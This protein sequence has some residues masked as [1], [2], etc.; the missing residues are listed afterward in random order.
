MKKRKTFLKVFIG[1]LLISVPIMLI[2]TIISSC[3]LNHYSESVLL[4]AMD[5]CAE[6]SLEKFLQSEK[7]ST[8]SENCN[9]LKFRINLCLESALAQFPGLK[10]YMYVNDS[11]SILIM[12]TSPAWSLMQSIR[13]ENYELQKRN[14]YICDY[15][16]LCRFEEVREVIERYNEQYDSTL[17]EFLTPHKETFESIE[18]LEGYVDEET[19]K[20]YPTKIEITTERIPSWAGALNETGEFITDVKTISMPLENTEGLVSYRY[21]TETYTMY[22]DGEEIHGIHLTTGRNLSLDDYQKIARRPFSH[23]L[24][25][26]VNYTDASGNEYVITIKLT[27]DFL[28]TY[29]SF[30]VLLSIVYVLI[31]IIVCFILSNLS[32]GKLKV[33]YQNEDYRKAL[34]SSMAH[35]LKTPLT[36]MSGY[37]ENLKEN[38]QTDK[39]EHYA[40]AILENTNYMNGIITDVLGLAKLEESTAKDRLEKMDFCEIAA[41]QAE[42]IK[43]LLEEKNITLSIDGSFN[44]KANRASLERVMDNLLS[45]ALKYTKEGG[46]I[47]IYSKDTPFSKHVFVIENTPIDAVSVKPSK[48]WEPFVKG[49]ESRSDKSGTGLGLSIVKNILNNLGFKSRIKIKDGWFKVIIK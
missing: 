30:I 44:R 13:D 37:A 33:F 1:K 34:M 39:R 4:E 14:V 49:D 25:R 15:E 3:A 11:D 12:D 43:P 46:K 36:V 29:L 8:L 2:I 40:D 20:V 41:K 22:L 23:H 10:G 19:L 27:D 7:D 31:D 42:R 47:N 9:Y 5:Y 35:D 48:L 28:K 26:T 18:I 38:I 21:D 24:T 16:T 6:P 45:N 32:Y 17:L